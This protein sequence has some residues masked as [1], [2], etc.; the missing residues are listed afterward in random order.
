MRILCKASPTAL[1]LLLA[2]GRSAAV[3]Q[4]LVLP[5]S[6]AA[7]CAGTVCTIEGTVAQVRISQ[8]TNT[9]FLNCGRAYP[10][11]TFTAV[12]F[13]DAASQFPD[14]KQWEGKAVR[15]TGQV[16]RYRGKAEIT[17]LAAS[18]LVAAP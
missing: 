6:V 13:H 9:T 2:W 1:L 16:R 18:Q 8:K 14:V 5:D 12:I 17:L 7:R 15:V 3:A 11:Q 4:Q 10:N